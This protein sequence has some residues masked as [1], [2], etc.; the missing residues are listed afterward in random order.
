M[1]KAR[2]QKEKLKSNKDKSN[3]TKIHRHTT[4]NSSQYS[5][6]G[7]MLHPKHEYPDKDAKCQ[8]CAKKGHYQRVCLTGKMV[9]GSEDEDG[10]LTCDTDVW[11]A[12]IKIM[13]RTITFKLDTRVDVTI[14]SQTVLNNIFS[15]EKKPVLKKAEKPPRWIPLPLAAKLKVD[16]KLRCHQEGGRPSRLVCRQ[17]TGVPKKDVYSPDRPEP[18]R[19]PQKVYPALS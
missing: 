17:E 15:N 6:C 18:L 11:T 16:G 3:R 19:V 12:D 7:G 14:V 8:S 13:H 9:H 5:R 4:K 1:F 10:F 2:N